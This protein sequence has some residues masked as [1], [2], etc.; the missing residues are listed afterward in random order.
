M[1]IFL[2]QF[3]RSLFPVRPKIGVSADLKFFPSLCF[4]AIKM[5]SNKQKG[6]RICSK[7]RN[8]KIKQ[9]RC[10]MYR[11][12]PA[13]K[14]EKN[15]LQR[16]RA[17]NQSRPQN[18][19][20]NFPGMAASSEFNSHLIR[21][22]LDG[23]PPS[24]PLQET[25][26]NSTA[27]HPDRNLINGYSVFEIGSTSKQD[28]STT[29]HCVANKGRRSRV[30]RYCNITDLPN[31]PFKLEIV[32]NCKFCKVKRFQYESPGFCCANGSVKLI[33]YEL[34]VELV[35]LYLG[36]SEE[37]KHFRTYIRMY[38][39]MFAF[40]SLGVNY[41]KNLATRN[42]GIY[43]SRVQG[44]IYIALKCDS[45][46]DQRTYN[47][48]I[49]SEVA[50][51]WIED[52]NTFKISL[53]HIRIY[54]YSN[55]SQLINYYYGCYDPL[56]YS[57]LFSYGQN[58]WHCG[59]KKVIQ[60]SNTVRRGLYCEHDQLPSIDNI[61]SVEI[62]LDM[63]AQLLDKKKQKRNTVSSREYYCYKFQIRDD[64]NN[65]ILHAGR[66]FQQYYVDELIKF[67]TQRLNFFFI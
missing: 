42:C 9:R 47:L 3:C 8:D 32:P 31:N 38:N 24:C 48:P 59:I 34:P 45:A 16:R 58:G 50:A 21:E 55:K 46:L 33:H 29:E 25:V 5:F 12:M 67:E 37:S 14:Q 44:K 28:D 65:E 60:R 6:K 13:D 57:L 23:T 56:Q 52:E 11:A 2:I 4:A 39:N 51:I 49:S 1:A 7:E 40:T 54:T 63:E 10:E 35:N 66:L 64:E 26:I 17:S 22:K 20:S 61:C 36:N 19:S 43:T 15:L 30:F 41:D 27:H 62:L 18:P 53:P